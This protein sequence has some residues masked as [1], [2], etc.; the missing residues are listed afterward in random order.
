MIDEYLFSVKIADDKAENLPWFPMSQS[1][2][3]VYLIQVYS[4]VEGVDIAIW[5]RDSSNVC[6]CRVF[7]TG[8]LLV[9]PPEIHP[10]SLLISD[11]P[12]IPRRERL[13]NALDALPKDK[14]N[15]KQILANV[16]SPILD[17]SFAITLAE[18]AQV[19]RLALSIPGGCR[20]LLGVENAVR[21]IVRAPDIFR[22]INSWAGDDDPLPTWEVFDG[23]LKSAHIHNLDI[24][25]IDI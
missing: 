6:R 14:R 15:K 24:R 2:S 17:H 19:E 11:D 10:D 20:G 25:E 13:L 8:P 7:A 16:T 9:R 12:S 21:V 3:F 22:D 23:L 4:I 5:T 1:D 18:F